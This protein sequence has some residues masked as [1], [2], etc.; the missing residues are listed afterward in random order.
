MTGV[1]LRHPIISGELSV[2]VPSYHRSEELKSCLRGLEE[3]SL[4]PSEIIVVLRADDHD[5]REAI[6]DHHVRV[7]TVDR[8][9]VV[10]AYNAGCEA[11]HGEFIAITDDDA[12]PRSDW[13]SAIS[14]RF[15]TD[16][17]IGAVG[18]RDVVHRGQ[19]VE[20]GQAR[21]VGRVSWWGRCVGNHHLESHLQDVDYVKGVNM[22]FR[23]TALEPFDSHLRGEGAQ[24]CVELEATWSVRRRGWRVVYDPN[25]VVDHYPAQRYDEDGRDIRSARAE[26]DEAHNEVYAL[27]SHA[28]WW[29]RPFLFTYRLL[30][31]TRKAPGLLLAGLPTL[32]PGR[33]ARVPQLAAARLSALRTLHIAAHRTS[34]RPNTDAPTLPE[35]G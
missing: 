15:A 25:I 34:L 32:P 2:V 13:L 20:D 28:A 4:E 9:G 26:N 35:E 27:V 24:V 1:R 30:V 18:G 10:A 14:S 16:A 11:A 8:P 21:R 31:G 6:A 29:H 23:A 22:A 19:G 12:I 3:Q 7:V 5:S 33:R 17:S